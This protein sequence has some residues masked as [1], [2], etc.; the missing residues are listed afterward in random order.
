MLLALQGNAGV[1]VAKPRVF[2]SSTYYDLKAVR[3]DLERFIRDRGYDPVLNERGHISYSKETSP[4]ISCYREI[5]SCD[6]LV[7]IIGGRLG[8]TS[9][10]GEYSISQIELKTAIDKYKQV[11][12]FVDRDVLSEYRTY[13]KNKESKVEWASVDDPQTF[14]F[15]EEVFALPNNN[16][17]MPFETGHDIVAMLREQWA[18]LFQRLLQNS[19]AAGAFETAQELRQGVETVHQ[20]VKVLQTSDGAGTQNPGTIKAILQPN[21]PAFARIRRVLK[22]PY[23][24]YFTTLDELN[25]WLKVRTF[26]PV[27]RE[28]WDEKDVR[29]W[30][31][32]KD[33][34]AWDMLKIS[35][36]LFDED[37]R[38]M[39]ESISWEDSLIRRESRR[40][41]DFGFDSND[42]DPF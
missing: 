20:L 4:E 39:P 37:G 35:E 41:E 5:E 27:P 17:I 42:D 26:K 7:S 36:T 32:D 40:R 23:R 24:V 15:L 33:T 11:Y 9:H 16:A 13:L 30:I 6:I 19:T 29:E 8:S 10:Q 31:Y 12:I 3:T 38:F 22:V 21:H 2:I 1:N 34:D 25:S 18:G 14:K 28:A